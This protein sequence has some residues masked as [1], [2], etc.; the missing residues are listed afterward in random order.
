MNKKNLIIFGVLVIIILTG[1]FG[2]KTKKVTPNFKP[3]LSSDTKYFGNEARG[4]LNGDGLEDVAYL[5]TQ[6]GGGS[7]TF[8]YAVVALKTAEGYKNTNSFFIG[9]RIAPQ[10]TYIPINS[11]E[12]QV[13]YAERRPGEP[14]STVPSVGATLFLKVTDAGVLEGLMK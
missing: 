11:R 5:I 1:V 9:D 14:M 2:W 10:S 4:D 8:Y 6:D 7:G 12:L 13:N 3:E